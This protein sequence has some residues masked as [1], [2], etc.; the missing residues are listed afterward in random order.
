METAKLFNYGSLQAVSLPIKYK[1]TSEEVFVK[2]RGNTLTLIPKEDCFEL[3][4]SSL[5]CFSEEFMLERSQL[6]LQAREFM[7]N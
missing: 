6:P 3:M 1:F 2:Q 4:F 5:Y 7:F